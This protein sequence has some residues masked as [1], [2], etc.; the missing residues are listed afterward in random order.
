MEKNEEDNN[1]EYIL[2]LE[3]LETGDENRLIIAG[4]ASSGDIDHD[5]ERV[6]MD[7]LHSQFVKYMKNPVIRF[8]HG[9]AELNTS[10]IGKAIEEYTDLAGKVWKTE[11]KKSFPGSSSRKPSANRW[12]S[13]SYQETG[14]KNIASSIA[15]D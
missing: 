14:E 2:N 15:R 6:D 9:K 13:P 8:M 5:G 7:S 3:K 4:M 12:S 10:A 11:L 1:F